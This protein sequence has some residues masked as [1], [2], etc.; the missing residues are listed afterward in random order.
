[1]IFKI[2]LSVTVTALTG[3]LLVQGRE[4]ERYK[5]EAV[6]AS[7]QTLKVDTEWCW[8]HPQTER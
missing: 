8:M 3:L 4:V 6:L 7:N 1:M 2:L 5:N